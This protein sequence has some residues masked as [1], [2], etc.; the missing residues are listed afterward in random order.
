MVE[1]VKIH[2]KKFKCIDKKDT[3]IWGDYNSP[4]AQAI[5]VRFKM[6]EGG[7]SKGCETE[8]VIRNWLKGKFILLLHNQRRFESEGFFGDE[9][10][11]ESHLIY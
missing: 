10:V 6:C 5:A 2:R 7:P 9:V 1:Q 4:A 8:E 11:A 3:V